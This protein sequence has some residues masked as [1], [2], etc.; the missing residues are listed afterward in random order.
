[1]DN[2][3]GI[4]G[5]TI[6]PMH[7][8]RSLMC[9]D[10]THRVSWEEMVWYVGYC[11]CNRAFSKELSTPCVCHRRSRSSRMAH[12]LGATF[13]IEIGY[14]ICTSVRAEANCEFGRGRRKGVLGGGGE[15]GEGAG[16][17]PQTGSDLYSIYGHWSGTGT[18]RVTNTYVHSG[19]RYST[20]VA[21]RAGQGRGGWL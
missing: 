21:G 7:V 12:S 4:N 11:P 15:G 9:S 6:L 5:K 18:S 13:L 14:E 3:P 2:P 1:V 20:F 17:F 16:L 19:D 8:L 10:D